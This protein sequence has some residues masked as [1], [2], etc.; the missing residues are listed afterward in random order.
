MTGDNPAATLEARAALAG[1]KILQEIR[2]G[3]RRDDREYAPRRSR[4]PTAHV[5]GAEVAHRWWR[6]VARRSSTSACISTRKPRASSSPVCSVSSRG[7]APD[8]RVAV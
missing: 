1:G 3:I 2:V 6:T 7:F 8:E 5:T 4:G